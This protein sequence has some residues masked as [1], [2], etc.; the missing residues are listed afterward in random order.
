MHVKLQ[1]YK[2][3]QLYTI[4]NLLDVLVLFLENKTNTS[5]KLRVVY[6]YIIL[7]TYKG[8]R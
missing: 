4:L 3:K 2:I 5:N 6:N 1:N 8:K 7:Y